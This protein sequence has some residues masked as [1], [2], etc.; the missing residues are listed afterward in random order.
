[1]NVPP[2]KVRLAPVVDAVFRVRL[3]V[4]GAAIVQ[5]PPVVKT[6]ASTDRDPATIVLPSVTVRAV[7]IEFFPWVVRNALLLVPLTQLVPAPAPL[8]SVFQ[9]NVDV[10]QVKLAA[11]PKLLPELL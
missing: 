7:A 5:E 11:V 2:L 10:S 8:E 9:I 4:D 3:V 1:M 6:A